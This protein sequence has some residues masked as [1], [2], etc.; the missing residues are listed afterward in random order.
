MWHEWE[1]WNAYRL[2]VGKPEGKRRTRRPK[3]SCVDN[4]KMNVVGIG[5][6]GVDWIGLVQTG[7]G[8]ELM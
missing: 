2:L 8:G 5:W 4:I 7:I 3:R 6:C 1:N